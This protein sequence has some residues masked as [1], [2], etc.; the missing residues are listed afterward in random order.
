MFDFTLSPFLG[1]FLMCWTPYAVTA[2]TNAFGNP[3]SLSMFTQ[4]TLLR[5]QNSSIRD[6]SNSCRKRANLS[7]LSSNF[8]LFGLYLVVKLLAWSQRSM[9]RVPKIPGRKTWK[10]L[11]ISVFSS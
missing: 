3:N 2:F 11:F 6:K 8:A 10:Q 1:S 7:L 5:I 9:H 4:V